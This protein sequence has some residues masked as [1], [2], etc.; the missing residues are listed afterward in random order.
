MNSSTFSFKNDGKAFMVVLAVLGVLEICQR[1]YFSH[2]HAEA[3]LLHNFPVLADGLAGRP[4]TSMILL[5]NSLTQNG[6]DMAL[7]RARLAAAG[8][9]DVHIEKV[10]LSGSSPIEWYHNFDHCF[11]RRGE[12]PNVI[13]INMSPSGIYDDLPAGYRIGWLANETDWGDVPEVLLDDLN[14]FEIGGQ[15]LQARVSMLYATRWDIRAGVLQKLVPDVWEGMKWVNNG[16]PKPKARAGPAGSAA[17]EPVRSY[18]LLIRMLELAKKNTARPIFVA[19]PARDTYSI[20]PGLPDII[21]KYDGVFIDARTIPGLTAAGFEDS[22]HLNPEGAKV[23][24]P[25]MAEKL[26]EIG[27]TKRGL[28]GK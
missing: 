4:G 7:L 22:W 8:N 21:K 15:Y 26:G 16:Q 3:V 11:V 5:G 13:V 6:Y 18:S 14:D 20:E 17:G 23:F 24:T 9:G 1:M 10:A 19:M 28:V 25:F 2:S 27:S 12:T